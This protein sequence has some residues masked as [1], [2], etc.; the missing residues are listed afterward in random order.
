MGLKQLRG[1]LTQ[2]VDIGARGVERREQSQRVLAIAVST[3]VVG[4]VG[5]SVVRR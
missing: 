2:V 1:R 5:D 4:A 3:R